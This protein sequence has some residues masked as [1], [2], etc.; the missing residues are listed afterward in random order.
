VVSLLNGV[1]TS[2]SPCEWLHDGDED[3]ASPN[4]G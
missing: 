2:S 1:A 4:Q 3:V